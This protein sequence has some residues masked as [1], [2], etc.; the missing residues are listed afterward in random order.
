VIVRRLAL[1]QLLTTA[2]FWLI[3]A[4]AASRGLTTDDWMIAGPLAGLALGLG[5]CA[6][7]RRRRARWLLGS[8]AAATIAMGIRLWASI[9]FRDDLIGFALV[10]SLLCGMGFAFLVL[11]SADADAGAPIRLTPLPLSVVK[12]LPKEARQFGGC[13]LY[14]VGQMQQDG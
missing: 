6:A 11:D 7:V 10:W 8:V 2:L 12:A 9:F 1:G 13:V 5:W 14:R 4:V 3:G